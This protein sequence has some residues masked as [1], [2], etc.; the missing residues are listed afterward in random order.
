MEHNYT[1]KEFT[2]YVEQHLLEG[3]Y[4]ERSLEIHDVNK[5]NGLTYHG[6][7]VREEGA[8]MTPTIY[9]EDAYDKYKEGLSLEDALEW[10]REAYEFGERSMADMEVDLFDYTYM[11]EKIV[12]R[13]VNYEKNK[14]T[15]QSHP[16]I[17]M[18]DLAITFRCVVSLG[19][20][21]VSSTLINNELMKMWNISIQDLLFQAK[22][23]TQRLFPA[24]VR[25]I[26]SF[27][28]DYGDDSFEEPGLMYIA[29]NDCMMNGASVIL[30]EGLLEKFADTIGMDFYV[31][32]SSVHE[33]LF[34]PALDGIKLKDLV[35]MVRDANDSIVAEDEILSYSVYY[36]SKKGGRLSLCEL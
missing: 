18:F 1:L 4:E 5:N 3:W 21:G 14:E 29:S 11:S 25:N 13:I 7:V 20:V 6:V 10:I 17:R 12:F 36:Y 2:D 35:D 8:T 28:E 22:R 19:E 34:V 24:K 9:L 31:L 30:Y 33:I 23:N 15:L 16:Y 27:L 32:P 26:N